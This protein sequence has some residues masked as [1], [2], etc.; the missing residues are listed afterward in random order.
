MGLPVAGMAR[1]A[2]K[3]GTRLPAGTE[4]RVA[5]YDDP[6]SLDRAFRGVRT[7]LFVASDGH[8]RDVM[9]HHANVFDAAATAAV[10]HVVFTSIVDIDE[11]SPFYFTPVYR[12]AERRLAGLGLASTI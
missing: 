4:I 5:D 8:G 2:T 12:D 11:T 6:A 7:L 10:E 1:K 9:R 3:A